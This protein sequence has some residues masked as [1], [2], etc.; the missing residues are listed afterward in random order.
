MRTSQF[1][2][3]F[4][5]SLCCS[6]G[7]VCRNAKLLEVALQIEVD[8]GPWDYLLRVRM[9]AFVASRESKQNN[10]KGGEIATKRFSVFLFL[11]AAYVLS[12]R[13]TVYL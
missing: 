2:I 6:Q 4:G 7:R 12:C 8:N 13:S 10:Q 11:S 9:D 1:V 3:A 5:S